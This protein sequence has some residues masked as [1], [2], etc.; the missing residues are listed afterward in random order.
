[1]ITKPL[2]FKPFKLKQFATA[3]AVYLHYVNPESY[4]LLLQIKDDI[5]I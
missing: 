5:Y 1:M 2:A 4:I 3:N